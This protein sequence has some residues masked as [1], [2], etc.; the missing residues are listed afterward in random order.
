MAQAAPGTTTAE[1]TLLGIYL[2]D[3]LAGGTAGLELA[4]RAAHAQRES[5]AG[6]TL[7]RLAREIAED[8]DALVE[9]MTTL[10]VPIRRYKTYAAWVAEKVGRLKPNGHLLDRSP[11]S[12]LLEIETLRLGV[13]GKASLWATLAEVAQREP[14][15]DRDRLT[16]LQRRAEEQ[17]KLLE[18]MRVETSAE[19]FGRD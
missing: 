12:S 14:R 5:P 8:K 17:A 6:P 11:L 4:R 9:I 19:V 2:N 16:E 18:S 10:G 13:Q 1:P 3:H 15:L 7:D